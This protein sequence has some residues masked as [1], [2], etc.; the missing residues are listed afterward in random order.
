MTKEDIGIRLKETI[1]SIIGLKRFEKQAAGLELTDNE[2]AILLAIQLLD[3]EKE[4][5][6][7]EQEFTTQGVLIAAITKHTKI[8]NSTVSAAVSRLYNKDYILKGID[9]NE[10]GTTK[11]RMLEKGHRYLVAD[12][13]ENKKRRM[14]YI[15]ATELLAKQRGEEVW[16]IITDW[17]K[18]LSKTMREALEAS[19]QEYKNAADAVAKE[20]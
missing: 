18:L 9:R 6:D 8:A 2:V 20:K 11:I 17:L 16:D 15:R 4:K 19:K 5:I 7:D 12:A 10:P 1:E 3:K 14:H 13:E